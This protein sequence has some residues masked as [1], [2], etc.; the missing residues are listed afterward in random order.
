[1]SGVFGDRVPIEILDLV[2]DELERLSDVSVVDFGY[3]IDALKESVEL[4]KRVRDRWQI[5]NCTGVESVEKLKCMSRSTRLLASDSNVVKLGD[6]ELGRPVYIVDEHTDVGLL[7]RAV[8]LD[9]VYCG[10]I[11]AVGDFL[12]SLSVKCQVPL[13]LVIECGE[14]A[15][16]GRDLFGILKPELFASDWAFDHLNVSFPWVEELEC[17]YMA[18]DAFVYKVVN[19]RDP[20]AVFDR[21]LKC[22]TLNFP[23]L[24]TIRFVRPTTTRDETCNFID[25]ST[26]VLSKFKSQ[27]IGLMNLFKV[28]SLRNWNLPRIERFSGHR[29]KFD[30]TAMTGSPERRSSSLKENLQFL[31][32]LAVNETSDA[33]PYY[34]TSLI[35]KGV[36]QTRILNWIPIQSTPILILKSNSLE[37]LSIKLLKFDL[38]STAMVHGLFFPNLESLNLEQMDE[39]HISPS[40]FIDEQGSIILTN[41]TSDHVNAFA[42]SM[43]PIAFSSWNQL[44]NLQVIQI[45]ANGDHYVFDIENLKRLL[46]SIDLKRSFQ[47][48]FDE[49]QRFV[50]V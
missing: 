10:D 15:Y 4:Q 14:N 34:R 9:L 49:Q 50:V 27:K 11:S 2:L 41:T 3:V 7:N 40:C 39:Q 1:M 45:S 29:F 20:Q 24:D 28:H 26:L 8:A 30:E 38:P 46:P 33:T 47:T 32:D 42:S 6:S 31:R 12:E 25:L 16:A 43:N 19:G 22:F 37:R 21:F 44:T 36:K 48:F 17:D 13:H 35:P 5:V 23:V 18:I